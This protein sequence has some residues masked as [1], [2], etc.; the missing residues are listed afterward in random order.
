MIPK[1]SDKDGL[2][3]YANVLTLWALG[4]Y[5]YVAMERERTLGNSMTAYTQASEQGGMK[6]RSVRRTRTRH[7]YTEKHP[8][9]T[10]PC[11][12]SV[13]TRRGMSRW[14]ESDADKVAYAKLEN[15]S[16]D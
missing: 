16:S 11:R 5:I 6:E 15:P 2:G 8:F 9:A 1:R 14:S 12:D 7:A 10:H 13:V 4:S 3:I